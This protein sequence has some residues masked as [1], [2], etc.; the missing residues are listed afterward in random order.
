VTIEDFTNLRLVENHKPLQGS[1]R[2]HSFDTGERNGQADDK[3]TWTLNTPQTS[4]VMEAEPERKKLPPWHCSQIVIDG[5]CGWCNFY[6]AKPRGIAVANACHECKQPK[7]GL[8]DRSEGK[9][10]FTNKPTLG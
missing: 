8:P 3:K 5:N 2:P 7:M 4:G 6:C 1:A 9:P 10:S